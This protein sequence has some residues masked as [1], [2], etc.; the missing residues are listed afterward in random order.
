M[1]NNRRVTP[2][3]YRLLQLNASMGA[4]ATRKI[5]KWAGMLTAS[6]ADQTTSQTIASLGLDV[7]KTVENAQKIRRR[8]IGV[9]ATGVSLLTAGGVG[10]AVSGAEGVS[11]VSLA[12]LTICAGISIGAAGLPAADKVLSGVVLDRFKT[13]LKQ[14][15]TSGRTFTQYEADWLLLH[16]PS[17][18]TRSDSGRLVE[19]LRGYSSIRDTHA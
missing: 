10:V 2:Y 12:I 18:S 3:E 5:E 8:G 9:Y 11:G 14:A 15:Q 16:T 17:C 6:A 7:R 13:F 1:E 4:P 19:W